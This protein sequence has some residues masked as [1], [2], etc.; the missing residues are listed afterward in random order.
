MIVCHCQVV[1]DRTI[2]G[3]IEAGARTVGDV[4]RRCGAGTGARCGAC[5]PTIEALLAVHAVLSAAEPA[6]PAA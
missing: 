6:Q 4:G 5:R 3:A 1:S 2:R